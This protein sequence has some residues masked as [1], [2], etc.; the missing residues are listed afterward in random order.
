M[1]IYF[2]E[3]GMENPKKD[4]GISIRICTRYPDFRDLEELTAKHST[5][6]LKIVHKIYN[7]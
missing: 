2:R 4:S 6:D 7:G 1:E 3:I 5:E